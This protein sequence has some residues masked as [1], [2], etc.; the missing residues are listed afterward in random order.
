LYVFIQTAQA[1]SGGNTTKKTSSGFVSIWN[2]KLIPGWSKKKHGQ[3]HVIFLL[4]MVYIVY[5]E[6][7]PA[8]VKIHMIYGSLQ[9]IDD[10]AYRVRC[11]NQGI[12]KGVVLRENSSSITRAV[13]ASIK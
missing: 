7:I 2:S 3:R 6:Y 1:D 4:F 10:V 9:Y 13:V 5:K 11:A 12:T 8:L